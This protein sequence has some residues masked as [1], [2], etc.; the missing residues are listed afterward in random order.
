MSESTDRQVNSQVSGLS[1]GDSLQL[2]HNAP[3]RRTCD[4]EVEVGTTVD[5]FTM[6]RSKGYSIPAPT[7]NSDFNNLGVSSFP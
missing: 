1:F 2:N 7:V 3:S 5:D 6:R 4:G